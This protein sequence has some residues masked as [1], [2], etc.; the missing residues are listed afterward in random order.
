MK[1][2]RRCLAVGALATFTGAPIAC[3]SSTPPAPQS[4]NIHTTGDSVVLLGGLIRIIVPPGG[5]SENGNVTATALSAGSVPSTPLLVSN[6]T[7]EVT[8]SPATLQA[9]QPITMRVNYASLSLP[10]GVRGPELRLNKVVSGAWQPL[11]GGTNDSAAATVTAATTSFSDFGIVGLPVASIAVNPPTIVVAAGATQAIAAT[12]KDSLGNP[13]PNRAVTYTS[14]DTTKAKVNAAGLVTGV[15][16]GTATITVAS[17]NRS[18]QVPTTVTGTGASECASPQPGWIWCDDFEQNRLASYFEYDSAG[19]AFVRA[20]GVGLNGSYGMR[21]RWSTVG[22]VNAGSLHLAFGKTPQSYFRPVDAGTQVYRDIYW[23]IWVRLQ[24]G[25]TGG[26]ADKLSRAT[27]FAST[28]TWA[29][30]MAAHVW[31]GASPNQ[32]LLQLDP[33]SGTDPA[34][35]LKTTQFNDF[36]NWT[37][38]GAVRS[39]T[40]IFAPNEAGTWFCVEARAQLN[41]AG[42]SNGAFQLWINGAMEAQETGLNWLG[43]FA[44]YGINAV[45]FENYWNNGA[46][47]AEERYFDNI[48]VS[49]QRIGC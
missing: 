43:A 46:P 28:T 45:F 8:V 18:V 30:A 5:I 37:W 32:D 40:A 48:V 31:S 17:E 38:L 21:A 41:T 42:Q 22:Q 25:W 12:P 11:P 20:A 36:A 19:G 10:T 15:A 35:N 2:A 44:S 16:V 14:S 4:F 26:G 33:V 6:S 27:V 3:E 1:L 23:R 49:T 9:L 24:P 13:L 39:T 29:Q 7:F 47:Q 34:G